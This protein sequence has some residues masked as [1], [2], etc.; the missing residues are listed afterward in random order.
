MLQRGCTGQHH[1]ERATEPDTGDHVLHDSTGTDCPEQVKPQRWRAGR[2]K[3]SHQVGDGGT[4]VQVA[5]EEMGPMVVP[6]KRSPRES[7]LLCP[8]CCED[9]TLPSES[10]GGKGGRSPPWPL[11][12]IAGLTWARH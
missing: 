2:R 5:A 11:S 3:L 7:I 12:G 9:L 8:S 10:E 1:A 4:W 6:G